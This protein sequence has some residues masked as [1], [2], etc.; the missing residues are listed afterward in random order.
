MDAPAVI[1]PSALTKVDLGLMLCGPV[2][3][4]VVVHLIDSVA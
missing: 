3:I 1:A 4:N 2:L